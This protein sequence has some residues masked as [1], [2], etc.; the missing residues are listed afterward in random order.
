MDYLFGKSLTRCALLLSVLGLLTTFGFAQGGTGELTGLV[1]DPSGAVVANATVTLMNPSTGEKRTTVTNS[2]GIYRFPAVTPGNYSLE[3][4]PKGFKSVKVSHIVVTVGATATQDVKLEVGQGSEQITVEGGGQQL[5]QTEDASLSQL[6]DRR[7]WEQMP[8]EARNPNDFINLVAGA[9]PE[10]TAGHTF[11]GA[12]VNGTRTGTGNYMI[13]GM[14]NNEQGQGGVAGCGSQRGQ[15]G[16]NTSIS[17]DAIQE[18][19][20]I[21]HDFA[22]EYGKAGGFVTDTVL[23][24]GTNQWHGSLFEY[25]RVQA[26]TANDWFS[27]NAG[28]KDHLV[29][30]QFGGSIGGPVIKDKTFFFATVEVHR[31]RQSVPTSGPAMTQQFFNFVNSGQFATFVN[32]SALCSGGCPNLP[33]TVGPI[34]QSLLTKFPQAMPL[35]NSNVNCASDITGACIGEGAYTGGNAATGG[36]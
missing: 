24:G 29:R 7:V 22:A 15:G 11:R 14:D 3:A 27:N 33:T 6:I 23:K 2:A 16:A 20:V 26:L 13:E 34:F 31:L 10:E 1:S 21:T 5:I 19:R 9:V 32:S 18:Y 30:N 28:V 12:A 35:V 8:L 25:N 4:S 17:P 36:F